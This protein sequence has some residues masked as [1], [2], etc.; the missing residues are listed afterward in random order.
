MLF[1]KKSTRALGAL[2]VSVLALCML[3]LTLTAGN[4]A[5]AATLTSTSLSITSVN[6]TTPAN[7]T[8]TFG[9]S[10]DKD[11]A[12]DFHDLSGGG[13]STSQYTIEVT[14][15]DGTFAASFDGT[16]CV[17]N[18]NQE[19][20]ADTVNLQVA[21]QLDSISPWVQ[22]D[23]SSEPV[24]PAGGSHCYPYHLDIPMSVIDP[25]TPYVVDAT[26]VATNDQTGNGQGHS[27]LVHLPATPALVHNSITVKDSFNGLT[28]GP[29]S[30][31]QVGTTYNRTFSCPSLSDVP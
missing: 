16:V 19:A 2:I 31:S 13:S 18:D 22:V 8:E 28:Y 17:S 5:H 20:S 1:T 24:I 4:A 14:K 26:A 7:F 11:V 27:G 6:V 25:T 15:G 23:T 10:I 3:A 29:L 30:S 21:V 9:W 12:P